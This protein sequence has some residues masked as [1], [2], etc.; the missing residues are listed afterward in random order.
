MSSEQEGNRRDQRTRKGRFPAG[1]SG[2][3][4]G[5]PKSLADIQEIARSRSGEALDV[6]TRIMREGKPLE[7]LQAARLVLER[8]WGKPVAPVDSPDDSPIVPVLIINMSKSS[9]SEGGTPSA[10]KPIDVS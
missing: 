10:G 2:N 3:P 1:K 7:Q 9:R 5:R 8:A 4:G 6:I